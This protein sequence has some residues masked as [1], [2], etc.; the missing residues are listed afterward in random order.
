MTKMKKMREVVLHGGD[1][2]DIKE[3]VRCLRSIGAREEVTRDRRSLR[4]PIGFPGMF[5]NMSFPRTIQ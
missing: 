3:H 4:K 5:F 1:A 2:C